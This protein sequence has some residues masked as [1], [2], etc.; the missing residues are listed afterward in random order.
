[1]AVIRQ[2]LTPDFIDKR[3]KVRMK[4]AFLGCCYVY[5]IET[6]ATKVKDSS[7]FYYGKCAQFAVHMF[8]QIQLVYN[9]SITF[10]Q[11]PSSRP[12]FYAD[13]SSDLSFCEYTISF[14][15]SLDIR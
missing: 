14:L 5:L 10:Q 13:H 7:S 15:Y 2:Y 4:V 1:M 9:A 6:L 3:K 12:P 11:C 8:L